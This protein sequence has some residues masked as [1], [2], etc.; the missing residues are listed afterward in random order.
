MADR[1]LEHHILGRPE[2][3]WPGLLEISTGICKLPWCSRL[4]Q[5]IEKMTLLGSAWP[6]VSRLAML[7]VMLSLSSYGVQPLETLIFKGWTTQAPQGQPYLK[8]RGKSPGESH[9]SL[10]MVFSSNL[11]YC[12]LCVE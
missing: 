4:L 3:E 6:R 1:G 9:L 12:K 8:P 7:V 10:A 5:N 11:S 2:M